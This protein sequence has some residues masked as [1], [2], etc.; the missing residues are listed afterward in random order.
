MPIAKTDLERERKRWQRIQRVPAGAL[1]VVA[2]IF[3]SLAAI[4]AFSAIIVARR[5]TVGFDEVLAIVLELAP[6]DRVFAAWE[7]VARAHLA[8]FV[9][10]AITGTFIAGAAIAHRA[11]RRS[12]QV[13]WH[14]IDELEQELPR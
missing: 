9:V 1:W 12:L 2:A 3:W 8:G 6:P 14:R 11:L 13:L 10:M 5:A 7:T 4:R